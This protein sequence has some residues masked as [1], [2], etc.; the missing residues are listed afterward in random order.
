M[1]ESLDNDLI[2]RDASNGE[3]FMFDKNGVWDW[4]NLGHELIY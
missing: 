2:F 3:L 4:E 1:R